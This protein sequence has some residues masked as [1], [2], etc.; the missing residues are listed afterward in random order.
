[1]RNYFNGK[2]MSKADKIKAQVGMYMGT[3]VA[4]KK[5]A[6]ETKPRKEY[7]REEDRIRP[8]I[9]EVLR[10]NGWK[11]ARVE[12]AFRGKFGLGDTWIS[13]RRIKMAGWCEI[14][15]AIGEQSDD[16]I[17]FEEDCKICNVNYWLVRSEEEA[18]TL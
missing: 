4:K 6:K 12:P 16:Q 2:P 15:S 8:L 9:I 10:K 3:L 11:V 17:E 5:R 14:K 7:D 1:M 13:N 18:D